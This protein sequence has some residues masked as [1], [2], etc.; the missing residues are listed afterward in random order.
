MLNESLRRAVNVAKHDHLVV[1]VTDYNGNDDT[2]HLHATQLA[3]HNDVFATLLYDPLGATIPV[4]GHVEVTDGRRQISVDVS[5]SLNER[6]EEEFRQLSEKIRQRLRAIRIPVL[7]ICTHDPVI[8]QVLT[9]L[10]GRR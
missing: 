6:F 4:D 2:T 3:R 9:A 8:D 10:G 7:P 5:S 1:L